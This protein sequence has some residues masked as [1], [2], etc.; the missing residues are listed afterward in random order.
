MQTLYGIHPV[1]EALKALEYPNVQTVQIIFN[2]FRQRPADLFFE[3]AKRKA[4]QECP[5]I[6]ASG[7]RSDGAGEQIVHFGKCKLRFA[8]CIDRFGHQRDDRVAIRF[9]ERGPRRRKGLGRDDNVQRSAAVHQERALVGKLQ[10][11]RQMTAHA[12]NPLRD[13]V[14]LAALLRK[15]RHDAI[16]FGEL[17]PAKNDAAGLI[18]ARRRQNPPIVAVA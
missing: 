9:H 8:E 16:G 13:R 3:Q 14:E 11:P 15:N 4:G 7:D 17:A 6:R 18:S 12:A 5:R 10:P 2:C 1:E